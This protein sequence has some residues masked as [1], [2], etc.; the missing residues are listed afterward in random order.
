MVP[1][2]RSQIYIDPKAKQQIH[3]IWLYTSQKWGEGQAKKYIQ[4]I[5][6]FMQS[7]ITRRYLWRTAAELGYNNLYFIIFQSHY[8]FFREFNDGR[9]GI[10]NILHSAMDIPS[11]LLEDEEDTAH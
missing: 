11:R 9:L 3:R 2:A 1:K 6:A 5:H 4:N 8:I 10:I 7:I